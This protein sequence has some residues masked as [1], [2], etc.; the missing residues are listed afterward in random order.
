MN[1]I[2]GILKESIEEPRVCMVP[3]TV[4]EIIEKFQLKVIVESGAGISAGFSDE[5]YTNAG[6]QMSARSEVIQASSLL[7]CI[8]SFDGLT[9]S[10]MKKTL[11]CFSNPLFHYNQLLPLLNSH[12]DLF[13]LDLIPRTSKAQSMDLLSSM[14]SL[15]GYKAVIKGAELYNSVLPML[16]TAAGTIRPAKVLIL[17]AGVAGLQ[18]IATAKRLG[19]IV[20]A[21]DVRKASGEEVRSLGA[22]FIEVEGAAEN[23]HSGGYAVE[24]SAEYLQLQ[25]ELIDKHIAEASIVI[26]TANIPG[27]IAPRLIDKSSVERMKK[28][29]VIIDLAADQGGNCEL[30]QNG[31]IVNHKGVLILGNSFLVRET[32]YTASQLLSTNYFNFFK[33][34]LEIEKNDLSNDPIVEGCLILKDGKIVNERVKAQIN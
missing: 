3:D 16:T 23:D 4:K 1:Y 26:S 14:A 21:F 13:S 8:N 32:A 2:I 6:A 17:G 5:E 18:A 31:K 19:A 27:K 7:F 9:D 10:M 22:K 20:S 33:H 15:S 28:G 29:A 30:T 12:L 25:K 24:Q 11:I 34:L